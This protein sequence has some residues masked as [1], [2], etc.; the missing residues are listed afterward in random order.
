MIF[1]FERVRRIQISTHFIIANA[2]C[3]ISL[4]FVLKTKC[5]INYFPIKCFKA[6]INGNTKNTHTKKKRINS[7]NVVVTMTFEQVQTKINTN[8]LNHSTEDSLTGV[9]IIKFN[10]TIFII[11]Y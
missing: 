2:G 6:E 7:L 9:V 1:H 8:V 11:I 5:I 4:E 10:Q 3:K